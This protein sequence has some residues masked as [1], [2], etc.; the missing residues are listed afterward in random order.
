VLVTVLA[1]L[2]RLPAS[3][4]HV[5]CLDRTARHRDAARTDPPGTATAAN[6]AYV[7]TLRLHR[8]AQAMIEHRALVNHME[9]MRRTFA[10]DH[11]DALLQKT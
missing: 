10:F 5:L 2:A 7:T 9:W 4:G 1:L 3:S 8:H 6:L 11:R